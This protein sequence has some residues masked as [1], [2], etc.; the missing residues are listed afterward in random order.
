MFAPPP[1][2]GTPEQGVL[3]RYGKPTAIYQDGETAL[4]EYSDGYWSQETNMARMSKDHRLLSWE[5]V[6]T[7]A[8]FATITIGKSTANDVLKTVGKPTETSE[9]YQNNYKVWSYRYKQDDVWDSMMHVMFD[10]NGIVQKMEVGRDPQ[11]NDEGG[12]WRRTGIGI[13]IGAGG[14]NRGGGVGIGIGF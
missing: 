8:K 2:P 11:Y 10:D 5:Q 3:S 4:W 14:G 6:R 7:D 9:I 13:G 12:F 1:A